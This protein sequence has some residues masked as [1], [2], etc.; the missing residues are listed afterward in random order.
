MRGDDY[1]TDSE[2]A[3]AEL[4]RSVLAT[5]SSRLEGLVFL[6]SL[7]DPTTG[8][9]KARIPELKSY[10]AEVD[11]VL[12]VEH[13]TLFEDW[14]CL[15]LE[16]Q[17]LKADRYVSTR[18]FPR[19]AVLDEWAQQKSYRQLIPR[20]AT[21][22]QRELFMRDMETILHILVSKDSDTTSR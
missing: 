19:G 2:K 20:D 3:C 16:Q 1:K 8:E 9:Y 7:R 15:N 6:A 18:E 4:V 5:I 12:G 14:L 10:Q 17:T 22:A 21:Q 13:R 11:H